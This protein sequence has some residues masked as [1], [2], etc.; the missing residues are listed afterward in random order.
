MLK[1]T[2]KTF[3]LIVLVFGLMSMNFTESKDVAEMPQDLSIASN[4]IEDIQKASGETTTTS[5]PQNEVVESKDSAVENDVTT[6]DPLE[7]I[8]L[9]NE[10]YP[11]VDSYAYNPPERISLDDMT[12]NKY[13]IGYYYIVATN[14]AVN[15]RQEPTVTSPVIKSLGLYGK[16][17]AFE[18]VKGQYFKTSDSD[19]WYRVYWYENE[20]IKTGYVYSKIVS[21]R[22]FRF[23]LALEQIEHL[24]S[25]FSTEK[26]MGKI[27]NYKNYSGWAPRI[28]GGDTDAFG[29]KRDQS[30][31]LYDSYDAESSFRY[32]SDGQIFDIIDDSYNMYYVYV[33]YYDAY[34]YLPKKYVSTSNSVKELKQAIF[35]DVKNQNIFSLELLEDQWVVKSISFATSGKESEYKEKTVPGYYAAIQ[36]KDQFLYLDDITKELD[37][38]AP[39]AI[40][41]N[42]GAYLHGFPVNFHWKTEKKLVSPEE[43]DEEGILTKEAVYEDIRIGG[44]IDPGHIEYSYTLGT[45][46]LSHKCVRNPTSHAEF[47]YNWINLDQ[48][49]IIIAE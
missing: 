30:A 19:E 22:T 1:L 38:Y 10:G 5:S 2:K 48:S 40:R 24:E 31:P 44:P 6:S 42:G 18:K 36:K 12:Y 4:N 41:F 3:L 21:L 7:V 32:L 14:N 9:N 46:P 43:F 15:I 26:Q 23:E 25:F 17:N 39:Y 47:M 35:V 45:I 37:G 8:K 28:D 11:L 29:N 34:G 13:S 16:M 20:V 33:P 27:N 49:I